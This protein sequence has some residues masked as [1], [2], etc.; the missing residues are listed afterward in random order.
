V[1]YTD[2][3]ANLRSYLKDQTA[4]NK[5]NM[6]SEVLEAADI[7][8]AIKDVVIDWNTTPP[9]GVVPVENYEDGMTDEMW[10]LLK[11]GAACFAI[12][13]YIAREIQNSLNYS[14][15]GGASVQE[16]GKDGPW[17][18]FRQSLWMDYKEAQSDYK[19]FKNACSYWG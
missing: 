11:K 8:S 1:D 5:L 15:P 16:F 10:G 6:G 7:Q 4:H 2:V 18:M 19:K 17:R 14:S 3:Q 9:L 12:D 13:M